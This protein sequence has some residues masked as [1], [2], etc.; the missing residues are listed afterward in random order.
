M[1]LNTVN[2]EIKEE[3]STCV[4]MNKSH[5]VVLLN[6]CCRHVL[7]RA[8]RKKSALSLSVLLSVFLLSMH[9]L[10]QI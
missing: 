7:L 3:S 2:E 1:L 4:D 6:L 5:I 8:L 9:S 10:P